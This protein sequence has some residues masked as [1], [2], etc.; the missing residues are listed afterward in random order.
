[1]SAGRRPPAEIATEE[2]SV[3]IKALRETDQRLEELTHGEIDTVA[4]REGR[5]FLLHRAQGQLRY[6]EA[7]KQAAILNALPA[8]IALR[9]T[10]GIIVSVNE[11][12][13]RFAGASVLLDPKYGV[14]LNY[15]EM[16]ES[17]RGPAAPDAHKVAEGIHSVLRGG[18][19]HFS[20]EYACHTPSERRWFLLTV[21][22]LTD[23]RPNGAVV[24][25]VDVTA[26]RQIEETLRVSE[27]RFRQ[28][29]GR[30]LSDYLICLE[31]FSDRSYNS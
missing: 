10:R 6:T 31:R 18:L 4:Y 8:H 24:M 5:S 22:P 3:L 23:D 7:A 12:W 25:H 27:S 15:L 17:A 28:M 11:A 30:S 29:A 26:E 16:C 2:L 9:D 13:G 20:I 21:T 14:G 19:T 1:M